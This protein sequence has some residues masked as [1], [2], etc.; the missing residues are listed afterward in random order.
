M[1]NI[2]NVKISVLFHSFTPITHFVQLAGAR[3]VSTT[4]NINFVVIKD[5]FS[6]IVFKSISDIFDINVTG[7][8]SLSLTSYAID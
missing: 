3:N 7:I 6:I 8:R 5:V 1:N 4:Y 2:N